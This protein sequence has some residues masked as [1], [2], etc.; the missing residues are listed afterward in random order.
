VVEARTI[1]RPGVRT[2]GP[3][4]G[5]QDLTA[6]TGRGDQA[7]KSGEPYPTEVVTQGR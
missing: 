7:V 6:A 5:P 4:A 1:D 2:E 3:I